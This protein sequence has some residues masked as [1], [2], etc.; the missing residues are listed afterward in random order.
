V[1][2]GILAC[3]ST[4]LWQQGV[5]RDLQARHAAASVIPSP[6]PRAIPESHSDPAVGVEDLNARQRAEIGQLRSEWER[7]QE[8][9]N[10]TRALEAENRDLQ[11]RLAASLGVEA[12]D[13]Q[14]LD[15][16]RTRASSIACVNNLKQ[17]GLALRVWATDRNGVFPGN[18]MAL[19]NE[20]QTPKILV[21]SQ[22]PAEVPLTDWASFNTSRISYEFLHPGGDQSEPTRVV[23]RCKIHGH[24]L[25]SDGSAYMMPPPDGVEAGRALVTRNGV[26]YFE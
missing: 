6:A 19:T 13:L 20:L 9:G 5:L 1:G 17:I 22:D 10:R 18:L 16:M 23:G 11:A 26:L 15:E 7:L 12:E 21:C 4:L 25:L 8:A 2:G 24:I 3:A 14:R